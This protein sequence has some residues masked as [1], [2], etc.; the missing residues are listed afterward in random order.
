MSIASD[1]TNP[2]DAAGP[3]SGITI[4]Q[5]RYSIWPG[6]QWPVTRGN[7]LAAPFEQAATPVGLPGGEIRVAKA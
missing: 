7:H 6:A 3:A 1:K 5:L 4:R 2:G